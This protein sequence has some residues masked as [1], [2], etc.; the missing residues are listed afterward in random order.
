MGG[1][2]PMGGGGSTVTSAAMQRAGW[3]GNIIQRVLCSLAGGQSNRQQQAW[4]VWYA[5][6]VALGLVDRIV[7]PALSLSRQVCIY[8]WMLTSSSRYWHPIVVTWCFA[9]LRVRPPLTICL[10]P[11]ARIRASQSVLG[12]DCEG[13]R[14]MPEDHA[15]L[16]NLVNSSGFLFQFRVEQEIRRTS[17]KHHYSVAASEYQLV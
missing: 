14:D 12:N 16:I 6:V 8:Y 5:Q 11:C 13:V 10:H 17:D 3:Y 1:R 7:V 4:D 15:S 9:Q 2:K